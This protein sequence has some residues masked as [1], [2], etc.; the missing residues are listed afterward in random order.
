[1][2]EPAAPQAL[3]LV[4]LGDSSV[5]AIGAD[6]PMDGYVGRIATYLESWMGRPVHIANV[7]TGGT[8]RA[9]IRDHLPRV[10]LR[11]AD[12]VIVAD[13]NDLENRAPLTQYRADLTTLM[14]ALPPSRTVYSDLPLL[15]GRP[16]YQRVL[17]QV[18]DAHG[19][20]RAEVAPFGIAVSVI[21]PGLVWSSFNATAHA[22][23]ALAPNGGPYD[24]LK[25]ALR[26]RAF[27]AAVRVPR[28]LGAT[29]ERVAAVIVQAVGA[30]HPRTRYK[31]TAM[32]R[33]LPAVRW[34]LP[35][36]GWDALTRRM[37]GL[38]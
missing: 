1:M 6:Q 18:A 23:A 7:S 2:R 36:R 12:L 37:L 3:R 24:D 34:L 25:Q 10:D 28:V 13:S 9:I 33:V 35:D 15:P 30:A 27:G 17:Q 20:M 5:E 22:S 26:T 11:T 29:P 16:P 21:Q 14:A 4:A 32:A 8:T 31:V 19:I 38:R